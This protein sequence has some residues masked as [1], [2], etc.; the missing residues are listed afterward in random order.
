MHI[1]ENPESV[2]LQQ[3]MHLHKNTD[4]TSKYLAAWN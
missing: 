1:T 2:F 4:Y 3:N